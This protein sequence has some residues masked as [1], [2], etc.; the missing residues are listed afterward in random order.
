VEGRTHPRIEIVAWENDVEPALCA[1]VEI[2][3]VIWGAANTRQ[4]ERAVAHI[5]RHAE[6]GFDGYLLCK[7]DCQEV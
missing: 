7:V 4:P 1:M 2:D 5:R 6:R 3:G